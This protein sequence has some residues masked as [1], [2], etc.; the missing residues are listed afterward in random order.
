MKKIS[1]GII[2]IAR[3]SID[4]KGKRKYEKLYAKQINNL[5]EIH[6]FSKHLNLPKPNQEEI[7]NW[8]IFLLLLNN[9][10][11]LSETFPQKGKT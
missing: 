11:S 5:E 6:I 3:D 7:E 10:S 9:M 4:F 1:N 2:H 8:M